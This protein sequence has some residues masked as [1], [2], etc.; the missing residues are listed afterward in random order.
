[1]S[2]NRRDFLKGVGVGSVALSMPGTLGAF[3]GKLEGVSKFVPSI[4]EM[5]STRC[6]IEA[7]V[8]NG[9]KVF[10]QGN[11][12]S[13]ATGGSVCA[14]GGSG[15]N[16]LFDPK[17]LV[18]PIMRTG[19]RGEG[20]WREISWEE[21]YDYIAKKLVEIKEKYGAH[22]V[23]FASK[24]GPEQAFLNQ[25]AYAYGSPNT[26]DHGNTCPSGYA[27]ALTSVFG[28]GS[29]SRDFSNC[30]YMLN[31]GHNVY[32]GIVISYARG[33]TEALEKGCKLVSLD[34]RFSVLS[35]KASEWIPIR[36]AGDTA[37]MMAFVHTLIFEEL[38]D[39]KFVE[40]YTIGFEKLKESVKDYT[41]ERMSKE[42]DIPADKIV[43]ITRECASYAP[44]CIVDFGHR[45]TFT[46]EEIEFR[47]A[48][49]IANALLG[50]VEAKGGLYFPKG[51]GIYNKVAGE[52]VA[53]VFKGSILPK[54]PAPKHPRIDLIDVKDGE[55]SKISK[56]RGVYSQVFKSVLDGKPYAI[57]GLWITRSNPVMT[58]N[59]SNEVVEALKKLD[60][61]V[62]VDVYVSDTSQY[63]DIILPESTYL[64]RDEQFLA[65]NGKNPGYQVRQK[66]V[67]TIGDT[68]PSWQI[69]LEMAQKMGYEAAFPYKDM[70]DYRMQQAYEYPEDMFEVK[71]KGIIK[72]GI[73]LLA[74]DSKSVKKFVEKYPN[75]KQFLDADGEFAEFL[76]CKTKSG[77]IE[78]FDEVLEAAC[79]RGG[80]T[81]NDPKLK[82]EGEFYFIQGKVAVHTNGH[83]M[84]VPWLNTLMDDNAVWINQDVASKLRL[85][86]G[87]KIKITSK[88]GSQIASV[89]P[90][91]GIREDTLFAYFGFGHTSKYQEIAYEKGMSA[92]HLL[93]NTISP[94]TG[95]NVHTIGVKIEKV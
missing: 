7:R 55:F 31:F 20:K 13:I 38:Y 83:T 53:P 6:P 37:F 72:Y 80:L 25:F 43:A 59:N 62:S 82:E 75:S 73:P 57:R 4:C 22:S 1:M 2:V 48:I 16:Q 5:C 18:K 66:V 64:E 78:L 12:Y 35:S 63:A 60:L 3:Q 8:D 89:L 42:C 93:A 65:S 36:P 86:K 19:E 15:A 44:H 74:R 68:K 33:V 27:V 24:S 77:K 85:K 32:E 95:N 23:A 29:V 28:S 9:E 56:T 21:A 11:P 41:P 17:R 34:P 40:K 26:F 71:H 92:S 14:R 91:V 70:N 54:I 47:R 76:K 81:Y 87:D 52:K 49:A 88:V 30:K 51:P 94:V 79:G 45:A 10:I 50:N 46:P 39:K 67:E 84:N 90:T 58:V 69:Y 61:F